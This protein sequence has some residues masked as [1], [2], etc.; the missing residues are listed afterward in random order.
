MKLFL[1]ASIFSLLLTPLALSAGA[2][3]ESHQD[4]KKQARSYVLSLLDN[5]NGTYEVN[6]KNIDQRLRLKKCSLPLDFQLNTDQIKPGKNTLKISCLSNRPWRIFSSA[7]IKLFTEVVVTKHPLNKGHKIQ[8]SD[9]ALQHV[10]VT[11]LRSAYFSHKLQA[12]NF[13]V[14]RRLNRGTVVS[15]KHLTKPILIK[16]GD[17]VN[18]VVKSNGFQ[19]HMK[20]IALSNASKGALLK[21]KNSNSKKIIQAI[22]IDSQTVRVSL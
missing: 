6:I 1:K 16:K 9:L 21:V 2:L 19:I 13:I 17:T 18:I 8:K 12:I 3:F 10:N 22:A 5:S 15:P 20:G 7:Q 11:Q 14:K 4:I